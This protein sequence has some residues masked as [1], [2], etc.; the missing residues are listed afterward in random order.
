MAI[1]FDP[2]LWYHQ[3]KTQATET[4]TQT[5]RVRR[6]PRFDIKNVYNMYKNIFQKSIGVFLKVNKCFI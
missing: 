5:E 2:K 1:G 6:S 4:Y 3:V